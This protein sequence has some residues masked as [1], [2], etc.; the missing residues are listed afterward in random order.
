MGVFSKLTAADLRDPKR[1][2][3]W[4][5]VATSQRKPVVV[6]SEVNMLNVFAS[7]ER[8]IEQ[9]EDPP[10]LFGYLVG[11]AKW[12]FITGPQEDRARAKIKA[13]NGQRSRLPLVPST[14]RTTDDDDCPKLERATNG[15]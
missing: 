5:D 15:R 4:Y 7:A 8:A 1:L 9:G 10:A 6:A 13:L 11:R 3:A 2:K 12:E 14:K